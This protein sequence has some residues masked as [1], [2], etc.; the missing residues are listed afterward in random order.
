MAFLL[1]S[2]AFGPGDRIP[3]Q[4]A[5]TG[6]DLS[7]PLSWSDVPPDARELALIVDDP[8][9][10]RTEPWVHWV[11]YNIPVSLHGLP[12]GVRREERVSDLP[13]VCQGPNSWPKS[14]GYRGPLPPSGHGVHHYRFRLS[15]LRESLN[16]PPG[17]DKDALLQAISGVLI[18]EAELI[19]TYERP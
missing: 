4:H 2:P 8:D 6:E 16:L 13:G 5:G 10:P 15:A 7:P 17:L 1:T 14:C 12:Q 11:I 3:D 19:G 9:A 18:A